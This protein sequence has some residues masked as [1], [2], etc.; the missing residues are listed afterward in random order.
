MRLRV[1]GATAAALVAATTLSACHTNVGEAVSVG[2]HEISQS[3]LNGYL[4]ADG[5]DTAAKAQLRSI[6]Q[7]QGQ[8]LG[9]LPAARPLAL[10]FLI[11][12]QLL[13]NSLHALGKSPTGAQ[14]QR[15]KAAIASGGG[16]GNRLIRLL[17]RSV[18][19]QQ[20]MV[21]IY[22]RV[23]ELE[24][25]LNSQVHAS[26]AAQFSS[27]VTKHGG[28]VDLNPRYGT[29]DPTTLSVTTSRSAGLPGYLTLQPTA[30]S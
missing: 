3:R 26:T 7:S 6:V 18:G 30:G 28:K 11:E 10:H 1:L 27:Y 13:E 29:W 16:A 9:T 17:F 15:E 24:R 21:P 20:D 2:G 19:L 8:T 5:P 23:E 12:E 22:N 14:L 4:L 25:L